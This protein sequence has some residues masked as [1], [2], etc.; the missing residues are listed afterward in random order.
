M[1]IAPVETDII[2][3][4]DC[5]DLAR[6]GVSRWRDEAFFWRDTVSKMST[7]T[8]GNENGLHTFPAHEEPPLR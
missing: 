2:E 6:L 8:K 1:A 7:A 4:G 5:E 3:P